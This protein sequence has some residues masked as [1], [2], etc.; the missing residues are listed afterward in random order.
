MCHTSYN[1]IHF[2]H[3][4]VYRLPL[5][6]FI[7]RYYWVAQTCLQSKICCQ[8]NSGKNSPSAGASMK[9]QDYHRKFLCWQYQLRDRLMT[10]SYLAAIMGLTQRSG[11]CPRLL[12]AVV[13]GPM[14]VVSWASRR[15]NHCWLNGHAMST[16]S[17]CSRW[18]SPCVFQTTATGFLRQA[19]SAWIVGIHFIIG[20]PWMTRCSE[21]SLS[22]HLSFHSIFG[23]TW[24][25][26]IQRHSNPYKSAIERK[27]PQSNENWNWEVN[28]R[29]TKWY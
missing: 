1:K 27:H 13:Q 14:E 18:G 3:A 21:F 12:G 6:K 24:K 15:V 28:C 5:S 10:A 26:Q 23:L 17:S 7:C 11:V 29:K 19:Q 4:L 9:R 16:S 2:S 20:T 25:E 8:T 22:L